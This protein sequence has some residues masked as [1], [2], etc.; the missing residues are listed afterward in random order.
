MKITRLE[1]IHVRPRW[2]LLK[3]HTDEGIVGLGEPIVEGR[4]K[5]VEMAVHELGRMIIGQDP[6]RIEHLWQLMYRGTFYRGGPVLT[7]AISGIEQALWDILGK[8]LNAPVHQLL[9]GRM[10]DRIRMYGLIGVRKGENATE[11]AHA[12][13]PRRRIHRV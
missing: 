9:G 4:A 13:D 3:V 10:R 1:T 2:L 12:H 6:R 8:S 11:A 5:T 7:S